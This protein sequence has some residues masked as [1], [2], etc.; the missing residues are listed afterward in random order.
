MALLVRAGVCLAFVLSVAACSGGASAS[1]ATRESA[2]ATD[3]QRATDV[4]GGNAAP[5]S[6]RTWRVIAAHSPTGNIH[7][8]WVAEG[9]QG[10]VAC[11]T[12]NTRTVLVLPRKAPGFQPKRVVAIPPGRVLPYGS[13]LSRFGATCVSRFTGMTCTNATGDSMFLSRDSQRLSTRNPAL[14]LVGFQSPT[15][16]IR[17]IFVPAAGGSFLGCQAQNNGVTVVLP[18]SGNPARLPGISPIP[19]LPVLAYGGSWQ[20]G[21][22]SCSSDINGVICENALTAW[23][24]INRDTQHLGN[25]PDLGTVPMPSLPSGSGGWGSSSYPPGGYN[26]YGCPRDQWTNGYFRSDGTWVSGYYH[27]SPS[28]GCGGG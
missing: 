11:E 1:H 6:G 26:A 13:S 10:F 20:R 23:F 18:A 24:A 8:A 14:H 2:R 28:D 27:N 15:G 16:N 22:F 21:A 9:R 25:V 5:P 17:C 19:T 3:T 12:L 4:A 7:C